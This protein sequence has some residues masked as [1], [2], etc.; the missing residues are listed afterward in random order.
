[1]NTNF[2][3]MGANIIGIAGAAVCAVAGVSR[4]AGSY[5]AFGFEAMTL[6]VGGMGLMVFAGLVK[7]HVIKAT[8]AGRK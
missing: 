3:D 7:L 6:F 4:V 8:L 5:H 2:L 1:M